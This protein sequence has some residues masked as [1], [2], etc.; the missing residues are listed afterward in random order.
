[1]QRRLRSENWHLQSVQWL[2]QGFTTQSLELVKLKGIGKLD[3]LKASGDITL[4]WANKLSTR[5]KR[6]LEEAYQSHNESADGALI[7]VDHRIRGKDS[8][9]SNPKAK[10]QSCL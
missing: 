2:V 5:D 4:V 8:I 6:R 3:E 9:C 7:E 10:W 1:M